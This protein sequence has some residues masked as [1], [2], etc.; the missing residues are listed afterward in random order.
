VILANGRRFV[1]DNLRNDEVRLVDVSRAMRP[2]DHH[3]IVIRGSGPNDGAAD[4]LI[5][6]GSGSS[7]TA[8]PHHP[9]RRLSQQT[10]SLITPNQ[11]DDDTLDW[12]SD[13]TGP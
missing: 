6:D 5:W 11:P 4:V 7:A 2:G 9:M 12:L 8:N 1:A 13:D 3:A 10:A